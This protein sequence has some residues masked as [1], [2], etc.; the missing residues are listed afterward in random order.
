MQLLVGKSEG[1]EN[2]EHLGVVWR[3]ILKWIFKEYDEM[4]AWS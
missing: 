3:I 2:L 1:G 4:G